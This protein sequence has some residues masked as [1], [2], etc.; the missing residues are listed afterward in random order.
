MFGNLIQFWK[1]RKLQ[2]DIMTGFVAIMLVTSGSIMWYNYRSNTADLTYFSNKLMK[3]INSSVIEN[4]TT[5]LN[6]IRT[7]T[8]LASYMIKSPDDVN[9]QNEKLIQYLIGVIK[10]YPQ[11]SSVYIGSE[12]GN[13]LQVA[14]L[15]PGATYRSQPSEALPGGLKYSVRFIQRTKDKS[16][17]V[18]QYRDAAAQTRET[19]S[20]SNIIYD[21][22]ARTWYVNAKQKRAFTWSDAYIFALNKEPGITAAQPIYTQESLQADPGRFFGVIGADILIADLA[23]YLKAV[24]IGEGSRVFILNTADGRLIAYPDIENELESNVSRDTIPFI[25]EITN[26]PAM[27]AYQIQQNT[28]KIKMNFMADNKEYF[29]TFT[30]FPQNFDK[31]WMVGIVAPTDIFLGNAKMTQIRIMLMSLIIF[32]MSIVFIIL[33]SRNISK[34]IVALA[35]EALK[36]RDFKLDDGIDIHSNVFEIHHLNEAIGAMRKSLQAFGKFVPTAVVK[37]LTQRGQD[38]KIGGREKEI[39]LFFSDIE[40][41]TNV[42]EAYPPEK[43]IPHLSEYF[44]VLTTIVQDYDGTVDKYIGD[45][46]MAF[47]GAPTPDKLHP[48]HACTAALKCQKALR[49]LNRKW[50]LEGKPEL[51]T[52]IGL[53]TGMALVGNMGSSDRFN[54][55]AIGDNVNLASRLEGVNKLYGTH[56]VVSEEVYQRVQKECLFRPLDVVAVKGKDKGVKIYE[57]MGLQQGD[58]D[59]FPSSDQIDYAA[60]FT[61]GFNLY[62]DR[63]WGEAIIV[64]EEIIKKFGNDMVCEMYIGRCKDFQQN[65][66][67]DDWNGV[68]HLKTK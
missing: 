34:P 21:H 1:N 10:L 18:W 30:K 32:A 20:I 23:R 25:H 35:N 38:V 59:L 5:Y 49:G 22:R 27:A 3:E 67:A 40:N 37:K 41:F 56:L 8:V 9:I 66:P 45:S 2:F 52:R 4:T 15:K 11:A 48:L 44:E 65:P 36:I 6:E 31:E 46:I 28:E 17:E 16:T 57:L 64:F 7:T 12:E 62:I 63:V 50:K 19:E 29:A 61:R 42:S 58:P 54:Y 33:L 39:T 47:W 24:N 13:F 14:Q 51:K 60:M 53:H 55:T 26:K 43:L 68:I